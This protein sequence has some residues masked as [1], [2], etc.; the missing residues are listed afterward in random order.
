MI[1]AVPMSP[2]R[3]SKPPEQVRD[4]MLK[5]GSTFMIYIGPRDSSG[6]NSAVPLQVE[7]AQLDT[8]IDIGELIGE[9]GKTL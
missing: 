3:F 6:E 9:I 1:A 8:W 5:S 7:Q 2:W 4:V